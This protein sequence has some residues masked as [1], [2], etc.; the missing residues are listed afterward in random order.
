MITF[1][2]EITISRTP[3]DVF[4][5]VADL[6]NYSA[7]QDSTEEMVRTS[8]G[9]LGVG[10]TFRVTAKLLPMMKPTF[11]GR[12]IEYDPPNKMTMETS[13]G[14]PFSV[15]G[16]YSFQPI[17]GGTR[18]TFDGT[19]KMKGLLKLIEPLMSGSLRKQQTAENL[20]LKEILEGQP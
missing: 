15:T 14:A 11:S 13:G 18:M 9:P 16:S 3:E 19:F 6:G 10:S 5:F 4:A 1:R 7:W 17:E 12:V 8:E 2:D 20:K